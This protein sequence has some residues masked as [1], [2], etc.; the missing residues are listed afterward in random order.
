MEIQGQTGAE[1]EGRAIQ[2]LPHLGIH[3]TCRQPN[4]DTIVDAKK[5]MMTGAWYSRLL[6]DSAR[7]WS[8]WMQMLTANLHPDYR[9][10]NA[11]V[12]G[13]TE[14]AE[15]ALSGIT[16]RGGTWFCEGLMPQCRGMLGWWGG[17]G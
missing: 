10:P 13:S 4:L 3:P 11:G 17:S 14:G 7:S 2:R 16:G 15:G 8:I 6:R 12:R 1:A 5:C 9:H